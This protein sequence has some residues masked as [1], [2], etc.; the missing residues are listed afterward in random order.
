MNS[1]RLII[2]QYR[3]VDMPENLRAFAIFPFGCPAE[4]RP[5]QDRFDPGRIHWAE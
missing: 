5:Q 4:E 2:P 3:E 1:Y